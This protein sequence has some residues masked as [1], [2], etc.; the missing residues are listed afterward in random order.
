[1][2]QPAVF[3]VL[4]LLL[5]THFRRMS[6]AVLLTALEMCLLDPSGDGQEALRLCSTIMNQLF[7]S[8]VVVVGPDALSQCGDTKPWLDQL[9]NPV[10]RPELQELVRPVLRD[11]IVRLVPLLLPECHEIPLPGSAGA[12]PTGSKLSGLL[13]HN[14]I[15]MAV[16]GV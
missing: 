10:D 5:R 1:M 15:F 9:P 6:Q 14:I 13:P 12:D 4:P 11:L 16:A 8:C 2:S 7:E 3:C